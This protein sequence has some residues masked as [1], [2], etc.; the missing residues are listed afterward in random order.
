M[1]PLLDT[2]Q[3]GREVDFQRRLAVARQA[4]GPADA[5][6]AWADGRA[7]TLDQAL[8]EALGG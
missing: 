5:N 8:V 7:L 6:A 3:D 2:L 1:P 4:L